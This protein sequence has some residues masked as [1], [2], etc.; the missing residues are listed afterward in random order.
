MKKNK[1][2]YEQI[3]ADLEIT[4]DSQILINNPLRTEVNKILVDFKVENLRN[5]KDRKKIINF[6]K[7]SIGPI[8]KKVSNQETIT[9]EKRA[10]L[11]RYPPTTSGNIINIKS[12]NNNAAA[13]NPPL[14]V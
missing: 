8:N 1:I 14:F 7:S 12:D 4:K 9:K 13:S 11:I 2:R 6:L 10:S 3:L 5:M